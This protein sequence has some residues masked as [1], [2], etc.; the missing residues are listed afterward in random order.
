MIRE[1]KKREAMEILERI[2]VTVEV[3][4]IRKIKEEREDKEREGE[5]LLN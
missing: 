4:E 3:K 5:M 1:G 2:R